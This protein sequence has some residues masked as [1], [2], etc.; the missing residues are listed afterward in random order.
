MKHNKHWMVVWNKM[1]GDFKNATI[2]S[3]LTEDKDELVNGFQKNNPE[4]LV[5]HIGE[6][7][8]PPKTYRSLDYIN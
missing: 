3:N 5:I 8:L 4:Y 7:A 2:D 1:S 6:G